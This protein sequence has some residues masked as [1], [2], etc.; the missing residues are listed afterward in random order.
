MTQ[1]EVLASMRNVR[2]GYKV[3]VSRGTRIGR[4]STERFNR[5]PDRRFLSLA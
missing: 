5:P 3:D 1:I 2:C 4:V